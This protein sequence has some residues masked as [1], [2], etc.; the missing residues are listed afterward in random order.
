MYTLIAM[1]HKHNSA[2]LFH[3]INTCLTEKHYGK[4]RRV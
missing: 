4:S 1:N 3:N 2:H